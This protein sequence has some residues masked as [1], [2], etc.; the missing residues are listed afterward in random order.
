M[1]MFWRFLGSRPLCAASIVL[2]VL[3]ACLVGLAAGCTIRIW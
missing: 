3:L 2:L 1:I